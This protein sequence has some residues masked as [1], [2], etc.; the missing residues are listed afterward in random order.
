MPDWRVPNGLNGLLASIV[1]RV[2]QIAVAGGRADEEWQMR[3][4]VGGVA[5]IVEAAET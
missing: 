5:A 4:L 3:R 2:E 1:I